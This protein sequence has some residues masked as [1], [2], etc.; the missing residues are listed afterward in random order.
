[1]ETIE[2]ERI[3]KKTTFQEVELDVSSP[4]T[5]S[6]GKPHQIAI[7]VTNQGTETV[8]WG[9]INGYR[10][11]TI[12]VFDDKDKAVAFTPLGYSKMGGD[13]QTHIKYIREELRSG[14]F[15]MWR[16]DL[17][18]CFEL[19]PGD[20]TVSVLLELESRQ[21]KLPFEVPVEHVRFQR[22]P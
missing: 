2:E 3:A 14:L 20:Y 17:A 21:D 11:C 12:R 19:T 22:T 4:R 5:S 6:I 7:V 9:H 15:H 13:T 16:I 1:M 18:K 8:Y 10:D